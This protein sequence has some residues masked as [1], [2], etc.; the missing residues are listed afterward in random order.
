MEADWEVDL[1]PECPVIDVAWTGFVDLQ[2]NPDGICEISEATRFPNLAAALLR[3]NARAVFSDDP[4][5][6]LLQTVKCDL[7]PTGPCDP[8][9]MEAT[10]ET[11]L[12]GT[13]CYIDL[14]PRRDAVFH[15]LQAAEFWAR[16]T[17]EGLRS[18]SSSACRVDLVI[19]KAVTAADSG[20]GMTAYIAACGASPEAS[21]ERLGR[22][23]EV[24]AE[25]VAS[26]KNSASS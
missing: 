1:G 24:F 9:E 13:A 17:T 19:R 11:S 3:L 4:E 18:Q 14:V 21:E 16:N 25:T 5:V 8:Y 26:V 12:C 2:Q 7:W 22:A 15:S 10:P 6:V 20:F 23:L